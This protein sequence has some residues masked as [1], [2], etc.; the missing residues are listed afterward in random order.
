[1]R[2]KKIFLF[3]CCGLLIAMQPT[4]GMVLSSTPEQHSDSPQ[5]G[6][7]PVRS[8]E[9]QSRSSSA[10]AELNQR[11]PPSPE[12]N[13]AKPQRFSP[14]NN[15]NSSESE[16]NSRHQQPR[17]EIKITPGNYLNS[18]YVIYSNSKSGYITTTH[19]GD[20]TLFKATD[21]QQIR[22]EIWQI[23]YKNAKEEPQSICIC[24]YMSPQN[25]NYW[26]TEGKGSNTFCIELSPPN[27]VT[28][29]SK[30]IPKSTNTEL[31]SPK[32]PAT[33]TTK[34]IAYFGFL[35]AFIIAILYQNNRLPDLSY[36]ILAFNAS[37]KAFGA[38][39]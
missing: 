16:Q 35:T 39:A 14:R 28:E 8:D 32:K 27:P 15:T 13:L 19:K 10:P 20:I 11:L 18:E 12:K 7:S 25:Y 23:N 37:L 26:I 24:A 2:S 36:Y 5:R 33:I 29:E 22:D 4:T 1:M 34:K 30:I 3:I 6:R 9:S 31:D 17:G 21:I 38:N